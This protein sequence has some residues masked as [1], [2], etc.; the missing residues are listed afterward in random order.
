MGAFAGFVI[1]LF[2]VAVCCGLTKNAASMHRKSVLL[3]A[4]QPFILIVYPQ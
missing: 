2:P 4:D 3:L 1:A